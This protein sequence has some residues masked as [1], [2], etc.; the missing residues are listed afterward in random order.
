MS[1]R[2]VEQPANPEWVRQGE[3][4]RALREARGIPLGEFATKLNK[5]Y[6][7]VSNIEAGRK[8]LTPELALT[9]ANLLAVRPVALLRPDQFPEA[10]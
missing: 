3:T 2:I 5:S 8:R 10:S 9:A 7:Y 6:S 4:L 1:P